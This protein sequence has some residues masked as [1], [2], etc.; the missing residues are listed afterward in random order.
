MADHIPREFIDLLL[1][2]INLVEL[3]NSY[4]PLQK[5]S[6][7]NYFSCCP[8]HQEK[9]ASFSVSQ[10]K[11]FYYCFGCGAHGNAI[12]FLMQYDRLNF[13][14]AVETLAR[15]AGM[16]V[17]HQRHSHKTHDTSLFDLV[18]EVSAYYYQQMCNAKRAMDYL[19][20]RGISGQVARD[21]SL[22]YA[23]NSWDNLLVNFGRNDHER[24]KLLDAGLIIKKSE[25]GYY[26]RF[27]DR[28]I[29]PIHDYR[30]RII[31]FGGRILESGEPKYLN[32]PE[33]VLF[34]KSHELYGLYQTLKV[35]RQLN[36]VLI[37]EGYMDVIAL[38]QNGI[39][40]AVATMGTATSKY[41]LDR[42]F[43][44][45]NELVFC[46][47]GDDAGRKAAWRA[48]ETTFPLIEDGKQVRFLFLP[49]KED[50]DSLV[51]KEGRTLF[52][53]RINTALPLADFFFQSL[54]QQADMQT[55]E[56]RAHFASQALGYLQKFSAPLLQNILLRELAKRSRVDFNTLKQQLKPESLPSTKASMTKRKEVDINM[57]AAIRLTLMLLIQH[58][59]LAVLL[60]EPPP[61]WHFAGYSLFLKLLE[62][63]QH[64]PHMS[65]GALREYF[66]GLPEENLIA[67]L[68]QIEHLIPEQGLEKE[69]LG[70]YQ[71]VL[72]YGYNEEINYLLAKGAEKELTFEEK[73]TLTTW[74]TKKQGLILTK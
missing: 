73:Q 14:E 41:H 51:R 42:L 38:F 11:Q 22:G 8:F 69:F 2:K 50:P 67:K 60:T 30:G 15:L 34:Q 43:R 62:I 64:S 6:G 63:A 3:I 20:G 7:S 53:K 33:T 21:F 59:K 29:F 1:A 71:R 40:Y 46:F 9:S 16:E 12:D 57:P 24:K 5:K 39:T 32:S 23:V 17:P 49:E 37:V 10:P 66:R 68:A 19:K 72:S 56:G 74:I 27:R 35:N 61:I 48:L 25:G 31:G 13:L 4:F 18:A 70:A 47:D 55:M 58:P 65:T 52:E 28:I 45:T 44:Y 26:D 36:R 54:S